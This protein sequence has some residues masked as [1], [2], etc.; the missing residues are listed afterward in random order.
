[1]E[2]A[3]LSML[4]IFRVDILCLHYGSAGEYKTLTKTVSSVI[5]VQATWKLI[6][7]VASK[8]VNNMV[9]FAN[10][11]SHISMHGDFFH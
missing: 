6:H 9:S 2:L 7:L 5:M 4:F 8:V 1:M 10:I 11:S 3:Y